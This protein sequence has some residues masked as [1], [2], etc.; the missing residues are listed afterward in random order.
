MDVYTLQSRD[1][2]QNRIEERGTKMILEY[3]NRLSRVSDLQE[4]R[5]AKSLPYQRW[6]LSALQSV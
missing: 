5:I 1:R 6:H 4:F 3:C 2:K